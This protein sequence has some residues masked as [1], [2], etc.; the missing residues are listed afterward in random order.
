MNNRINNFH[1]YIEEYHLR[2]CTRSNCCKLNL[3]SSRWNITQY[4]NRNIFHIILIIL[5]M[6]ERESFCL[7]GVTRGGE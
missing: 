4:I 2:L 1:E 7:L 6:L 5:R 3:N